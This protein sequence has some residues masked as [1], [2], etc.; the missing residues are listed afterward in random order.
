LEVIEKP[1]RLSRDA[2]ASLGQTFSYRERRGLKTDSDLDEL[3]CQH[4]DL[5]WFH[6]WIRALS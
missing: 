1:K 2:L 6:I 5:K 3:V 4:F